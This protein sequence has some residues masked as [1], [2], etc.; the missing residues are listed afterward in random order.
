M[1]PHPGFLAIALAFPLAVLANA[2]PAGPPDFGEARSILRE[3]GALL[4]KID[5]PERASIA[6]NI[7]GQQAKAG[8]LAGAL[9]AIQSVEENDRG[10]G[11]HCLAYSL[12][13]RGEWRVAMRI[14]ADQPAG[15]PRVFPYMGVAFELARTG[16]F[17]NALSV[18]EVIRQLPN[19]V[20]QYFDVLRVICAEQWKTGNVPAA[21]H[22]F[23]EALDAAEHMEKTPDLAGFSIA[24]WCSTL[25]QDLAMMGYPQ[26]A[27]VVV[28]RLEDMT[29]AERDQGRKRQLLGLLAPA[30]AMVGDFAAALESLSLLPPGEQRDAAMLSV[31]QQQARLGDPARARELAQRVSPKS[32]TDS[33]LQQFAYALG[34]AGD[35][36]GALETLE[37]VRELGEKEYGLAQLALQQAEKSDPS[38]TVTLM[39]AQEAHQ[40][41][42]DGARPFV[43]ELF[44]VTRAVQGDFAGSVEI[45]NGLGDKGRTWPLW[46]LTELMVAAGKKNEA[47]A[48]AHAQKG[49]L[50]RAYALLGTAS[51]LIGQAE[52]ASKK[53]GSA[54]Q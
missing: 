40:A 7:A 9:T 36:T 47:L 22:T 6:A 27:S 11:V 42:G 28:Q 4:P 38:S 29:T 20:T 25:V 44:A 54:K 10:I 8:D 53:S 15:V 46:N 18:A 26:A 49:H 14:I 1:A 52:A 19:G 51:E 43:P 30:Q 2:V 5:E 3:A 50:P 24:G 17:D 23:D 33:A 16:D 41:A 32:W 21:L 12:V 48:L 39:L 35:L 31:I 37:R 45:L 34:T 13:A